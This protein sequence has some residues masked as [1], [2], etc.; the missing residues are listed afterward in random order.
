MIFTTTC[1]NLGYSK[2]ISS[3]G[4]VYENINTCGSGEDN[5]NLQFTINKDTEFVGFS[6]PAKLPKFAL[7]DL[8]VDYLTTK[9][10][11][12]LILKKIALRKD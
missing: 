11:N 6:D 1:H 9:K 8:V 10:G 7:I 2:R 3:E 5:S 4:A 12:F